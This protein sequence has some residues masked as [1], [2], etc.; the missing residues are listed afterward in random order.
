MTAHETRAADDYCPRGL[1]EHL[2]WQVLP[3]QLPCRPPHDPQCRARDQP[4]LALFQIVVAR[5]P[6]T[7]AWIAAHGRT[8]RFML[9]FRYNVI[10]SGHLHR[11]RSARAMQEAMRWEQQAL[12][13]GLH[14]GAKPQSDL[15]ELTRSPSFKSCDCCL[16]LLTMTP[17]PPP[18]SADNEAALVRIE[19]QHRMPSRD[20]IVEQADVVVAVATDAHV[21][22]LRG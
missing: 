6:G 12:T 14:V 20:G 5:I 18:R 1:V 22:G 17:L 3:L 19:M 10:A 21:G 15:A 7:I 11:N 4:C 9:P 16:I 2:P 13:H 8:R